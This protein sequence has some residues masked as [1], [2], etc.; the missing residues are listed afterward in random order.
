MQIVKML[1]EKQVLPLVIRLS[2][3]RWNTLKREIALKMATI[4]VRKLT[5]RLA[6]NNIPC[7]W[8]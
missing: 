5:E 4:Y 3:V 7:I 1:S 6:I 8:M 2:I